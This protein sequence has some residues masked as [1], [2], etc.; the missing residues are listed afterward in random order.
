MRGNFSLKRKFIALMVGSSMFSILCVG[1]FF[2]KNMSDESTRQVEVYRQTLTEAVEAQLINETQTAVSVIEEVRQKQLNGEITEEQAR[3]E[4]ADRVRDMRYDGG[5]GYFWVDTYEGVN[6]VLLGRPTEGKSRIDAV[7]PKGRHFIR[8]MIENGRKPGGGFTDL[9][10]AKPNETTPLP[11][12]NYTMAYEPYNWVLGTGVWID[13]IDE[14]VAVE[15]A[16]AADAFHSALV[17][18][19]I[20]VIILQ[21]VLIFAAVWVSNLMIAPITRV[22]KRLDVL[23]TGDFSVDKSADRDDPDDEI[24]E[25]SRALDTLQDSIR[26]MMRQVTESAAQ[27]A[28]SAAQLTSSAEQSASVSG[29]V[30]DSIVKVAGACSE[31]FTEVENAG[32]Q[33][34]E[35]SRH[36]NDFADTIAEVG[37]TVAQ[38][39]AAANEGEQKVNDAVEQMKQIAASV[40]QSAEVITALGEESNKIGRIVDAISAIAEQTNLLSLN[41]AIEAARAGEHGRGF[42]VVADEVRKLAEQSSD[43]AAEIASLIGSIQTKANNAVQVMQEG[44]SQVQI[45]AGAVDGAGSAFHDIAG[46]IDQVADESKSMEG[47]VRKLTG[48]TEVIAKAV[49][50]IS[51]MS[52]DVASESE[53]VS[54]ATEEQTAT[55]H[56]IAG[57]SR[58][59]SEMSQNMQTAVGKFKI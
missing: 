57:A 43:S 40:S 6:V 17:K 16:A 37:R 10:F 41:A 18:L 32:T 29:Q 49:E 24:G 30:A 39:S 59:L 27:V 5:A 53:T 56:E 51:Q 3:K 15:E 28:D 55:M 13:D 2:I 45:G 54:A 12:R 14:K 58:T 19:L 22:T 7:D 34:E 8:E 52:R 33:T 48:S 44:V 31:Q 38:T 47:I 36:M 42:A 21:A 23:A 9:M 50:K 11:K 20:F 35:L 25:M 1:A 4:A 26:K 46:M